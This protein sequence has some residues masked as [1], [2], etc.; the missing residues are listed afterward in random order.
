MS[1]IQQAS[2]I[3]F[4][5]EGSYSSVN[6]NDNGA[7]S[8]GKCQWHGNRARD[9]IRKTVIEMQKSNIIAEALTNKDWSKRVL[10]DSEKGVL[11]IVLNTTQGR[12][13]QD[14]QAE[15]DIEA[16]VMHIMS[17]DITD[18]NIIILLADIENQGGKGATDRIIKNTIAKY[19]KHFIIEQ[20]MEVALTDK[21]FKK[22]QQRRKEV[23]KKLMGWEYI[24]KEQFNKAEQV[25]NHHIVVA[26]D[27][28]TEIAFILGTT[29]EKL[30][31]DNNIKDKDKIYIG[32]F[33]KLYK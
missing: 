28:L 25:L 15:K 4:A 24:S 23:F 33:I 12:E 29:V 13:I 22:Y 16:Y 18:N 8:V 11:S 20:C 1:L 31:K 9:I 26:G 17:Y 19:G 14:I 30:M 7:L 5:N 10:T 21:V 27:T 6:L 2:K 3:I 32:Q